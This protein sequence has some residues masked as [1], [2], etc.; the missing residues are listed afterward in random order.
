MKNKI[1]VSLLIFTLPSAANTVDQADLNAQAKNKIKAFAKQ[2]KSTLQA[3]VKQGGPTQG[4]QVCKDAAN[5]IAQLHSTDGWQVGRTSLK[6]RNPSNQPDSWEIKQ[7]NYFETEKAN[8]VSP[9]KL[10]ASEIITDENGEQY[11]RFMKAIPTGKLCLGC[12]GTRINPEVQSTLNRLY[13][14][15]KA[16]GFKLGEI[17]GAFT[18][19]KQLKTNKTN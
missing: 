11:F 6:L 9:K 19:S 14:K 5:S 18:L 8:G 4:I 13:P 17:R 7:L 15:D 12:H 1:L 10:F 3:G 16:T 2:L